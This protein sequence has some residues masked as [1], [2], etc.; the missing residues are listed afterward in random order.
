MNSILRR[1]LYQLIAD[2]AKI[3]G[4]LKILGQNHAAQ[5]TKKQEEQLIRLN[6][7]FNRLE[8]D[9]N[10]MLLDCAA[11]GRR[12]WKQH[13]FA[14]IYNS[15]HYSLLRVNTLFANLDKVK[16]AFREA[17]INPS[18]LRQLAIDWDRFKKSI[19][20]IR[21]S[22]KQPHERRKNQLRVRPHRRRRDSGPETNS[23]S[24]VRGM[25]SDLKKTLPPPFALGQNKRPVKAPVA[26]GN[27]WDDILDDIMSETGEG[28][29][30]DIYLI[31]T[32]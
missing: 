24:P 11:L 5:S 29:T 14:V 9:L 7:H 31:I 15:L 1:G 20:Q 28:S 12:H 25:A 27:G 10:V 30:F 26:P 8:N 2:A 16:M 6:V 21:K 13:N 32:R 19:E 18:E 17:H 3:T 23:V 4:I 22:L